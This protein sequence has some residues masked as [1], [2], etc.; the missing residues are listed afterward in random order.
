M[1]FSQ[2]STQT[3]EAQLETNPHDINVLL[4]LGIAYHSQGA[5]GN[6]DAVEKGFAC[7]D[8]LLSIEPTNAAALAFR[9]SLWTLRARDAWWPFT[10]LKDVEKG[11][12]E[13][14]KAV[15]LA[16][17]NVSVRLTRGIT[18]VSLPSMFHRLGTALK[19]FSY[20]L[21][22]P[23]FSQFSKS[24]QATIY[25]WAGVAYKQ[26]GQ[27]GKAKELLEKAIEVDP[28]SDNATSAKQ[29]LDNLS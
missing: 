11:V 24:F 5:A 10:K 1:C 16:P 4:N 23:G 19:D 20:L 12:D 6:E 21:N 15:D 13:M 17:E 9:G 28:G 7:F 25:R 3:L 14:D 29:E 27:K 8:T 22:H 18:S 2:Q 26:D